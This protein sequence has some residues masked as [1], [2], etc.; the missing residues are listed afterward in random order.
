M[1]RLDVRPGDEV[2][3]PLDDA[4]SKVWCHVLFEVPTPG[5]WAIEALDTPHDRVQTV[6]R[7]RVLEM[8]RP[9]EVARAVERRSNGRLH[10]CSG[11]ESWGARRKVHEESREPVMGWPPYTHLVT[12]G[13]IP[14]TW[15][16][17]RLWL[18]GPGSDT[19][20]RDEA[21]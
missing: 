2:L 8:R 6:G 14:R 16:A 3:V 7:R 4:D 12:L 11:V 13:D 10:I 5:M 19:R 9:R 17:H 1:T 15:Q 18:V 20:Q 21:N